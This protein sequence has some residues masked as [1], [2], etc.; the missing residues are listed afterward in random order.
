MRRAFALFAALGF[1]ACLGAG[2]QPVTV[3]IIQGP[4]IVVPPPAIDGP[5]PPALVPPQA[6]VEV[7]RNAAVTTCDPGGCWDSQGRRLE[8]SGPVFVTPRGTCT[9]QAGEVRCP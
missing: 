6:P 2:A 7:P 9:V 4:V 8:R 3:H 1:A 5:K